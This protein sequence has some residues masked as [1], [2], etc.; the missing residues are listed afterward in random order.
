MFRTWIKTVDAKNDLFFKVRKNVDII[1]GLRINKVECR[2]D[3]HADFFM[4]IRVVNLCH[5]KVL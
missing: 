5:C 4:A 3:I 1:I 2:I